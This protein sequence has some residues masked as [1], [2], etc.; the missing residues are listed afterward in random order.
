M[1]VT[2]R[3]KQGAALACA[4]VFALCLAGAG[5]Y[6]KVVHAVYPIQNWLAWHLFAIWAAVLTFSVACTCFGQWL[7]QR[8]LKLRLS[9]ALESAVFSMAAG[10][11]AFAL[12]MYVAGAL[13]WYGPRFS[14]ALPIVM[15]GVG[16]RA[17]LALARA[18]IWELRRAEAHSLISIAG[19]AAGVLCVAVVYLGAMTPDALN[20]DSTWYHL[21]IAQDYVRAGGIVPFPADYNKNYPA[22]TGLISTWGWSLPGFDQ[23]QQWMMSLHFEFSLFVWTLAAVNA[24]VRTLSGRRRLRGA[25]ASF[26]L[27]PIIFV[28][29]HNLGGAADHNCAFFAVPIVLATL[30]FCTSFAAADA[31]LLAIVSAGAL[32]AKYQASY[33]IF[34]AALV[35]CAHWL[36]RVS[37]RAIGSRREPL[38]S[39]LWSP[40]LVAGLGALL[41]SPHFLKQWLFHNNPVYPFLQTVFTHSTP[42]VPNGAFIFEQTAQE[43]AW[44]P[45]G[46]LADRFIHA[47]KLFVTFSFKPH[48]SFTNNV[49]VFGSLFTLLLPAI[50]VIRRRWAIAIAT[51]VA[52]G[53]VLIWGM[54]FNVDRN[55]QVFMPIMVAVTGALL[56][57]SWDMGML[58]RAGLV[59]LVALQI[60]WGGD[61]LIYSEHSRIQSAF[62]LIRSGFE[63]RALTRFDGYRSHYRS[64]NKALPPDAKVLLHTSHLSLGI[65]RD[66]LFDWAGYQ[67]LISYDHLHNVGE[68]YDYYR[69]L[70][71]THLLFTP[72]VRPAASKQEEV[73]WNALLDHSRNMGRFNEYRLYAMPA[74][75]PPAEPPYTVGT[76]GIPGYANGIYP[77]TSLNT[78]EYLPSYMQRYVAPTTYLPNDPRERAAALSRVDAVLLGSNETESNDW[79]SHF[80]R[81]VRLPGRF[82]L[83]LKHH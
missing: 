65:D 24:G 25:W 4:A 68:L 53:A 75:R 81:G 35:V 5:A 77:I 71:I 15:I 16:G 59:P 29:D 52:G 51:I 63:G 10:V 83:Y 79:A 73:L 66:V 36:R 54:V 78:D 74:K 34:P 26:F 23:P 82:T 9:S 40:L 8:V 37:Q 19:S 48:Y 27:F 50:L 64:I 69:K 32:L 55:L 31:A 60:I 30:R 11:V 33:M 56:V 76:L 14:I 21:V 2:A 3:S 41:V 18:L 42:T 70:G 67:G 61:A 1:R 22:L 43:P 13:K 47:C 46:T 6:A 28:Y 58:A 49:P 62:D 17:G 39:A 7:L 38:G 12:A 80:K 72:D 20:Y 44:R 45:I 57:R